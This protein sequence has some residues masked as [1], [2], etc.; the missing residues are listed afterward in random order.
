MSAI[1]R[2]SGGTVN[3]FARYA[4]TA[5]LVRMR[6]SMT[7][8]GFSH[9]ERN[10]GTCETWFPETEEYFHR[11]S[12]GDGT[13]KWGAA[14][15]KCSHKRD[16]VNQRKRRL[17]P[18][19]RAPCLRQGVSGNERKCARCEK[20][21]HQET[22]FG[23]SV[24]DKG[25]VRWGSYCENCRRILNKNRDRTR[26]AVPL[27]QE[28]AAEILSPEQLRK[29]QQERCRGILARNHLTASEVRRAMTI[30]RDSQA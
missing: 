23:A 22:H 17:R 18:V 24:T 1:R 6:K 7:R 30:P 13:M 12:R 14:C 11:H 19:N 16:L 20:W 28:R 25:L 4:T 2:C 29:L 10:C 15:K 26:R 3:T 21:L 5:G 8:P 9:R 27:A